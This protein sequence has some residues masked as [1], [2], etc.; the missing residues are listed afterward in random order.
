MQ[1]LVILKDVSVTYRLPK[2]RIRSLKEFWIHFLKGRLEYENYS[3][4]KAVN[5]DVRRGEA[6]GI[7]GRNGSGKSTLLKVIAGVIKPI[8]GAVQ[9]NG[10]VAPL[11]EL[12][13]GFDFE[14]TGLENIYLNG[15]MLG[16][17]RRDMDAKVSSIVEFSELGDFIHSPLRTYSSGMIARLG[18]AIATD[19]DPDV[20]L[21]DE[22][23][24][25]GDG[26]FTKKCERRINSYRD[27]QVAL[28]LVSHDMNKICALCEKAAWLNMGEICAFGNA[29]DVTRE[30]EK[31]LSQS[32]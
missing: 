21:V 5:L 10:K 7:V 25:V 8:H 6:L 18:F 26:A 14:M 3:A 27:T 28:V 9:V 24:G 16:F 15:S 4:L 23:L 11:L 2:E 31:F 22:V 12:G 13:A 29:A 32:K 20:L 30:Y 19:A 1:P 17:S